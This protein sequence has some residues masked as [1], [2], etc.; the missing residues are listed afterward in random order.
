MKLSAVKNVKDIDALHSMLSM[1]CKSHQ[2]AAVKMQH[3][4][5]VSNLTTGNSGISVP[6]YW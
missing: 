5:N 2:S 3:L 6:A 4:K 1:L